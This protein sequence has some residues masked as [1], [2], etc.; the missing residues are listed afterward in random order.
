MPYNRGMPWIAL[1][2]IVVTVAVALG[3][4]AV[5]AISAGQLNGPRTARWEKVADTASRHLN[6]EGA[7]PKVLGKLDLRER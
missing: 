6:G 3:L 5:V 7:P 4:L 2:A 1:I